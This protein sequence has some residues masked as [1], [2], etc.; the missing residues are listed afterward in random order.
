MR[1]LPHKRWTAVAQWLRCCATYRDVTGSIAA[2]V[3]GFFIEIKS[4]PLQFSLGVDIESNTNEYH[5][6]FLWVKAAGA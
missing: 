5:K 3:G 1:Q 6:Y 4:F 2:G